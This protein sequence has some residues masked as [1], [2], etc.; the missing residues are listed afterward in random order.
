MQVSHHSHWTHADYTGMLPEKDTTTRRRKVT[1]PLNFIETE[2][3]KQ[4]K[5][6]EEYDSN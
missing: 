4:N 5:K 2:K 3:V 6:T 1:V